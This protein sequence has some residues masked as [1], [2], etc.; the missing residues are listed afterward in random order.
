[1]KD[2]GGK[3][4]LDHFMRSKERYEVEDWVNTKY[5]G[6]QMTILSQT[7]HDSGEHNVGWVRGRK[8]VKKASDRAEDTPL[9]LIVSLIRSLGIMHRTGLH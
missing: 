5:I 4:I 1:M 6:L 9:G 3:I 8:K 7:R 2:A